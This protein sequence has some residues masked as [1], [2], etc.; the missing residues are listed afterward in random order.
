MRALVLPGNPKPWLPPQ[1]AEQLMHSV[2]LFHISFENGNL[3]AFILFTQYDTSVGGLQRTLRPEILCTLHSIAICA[4][5]HI[6]ND[7]LVD[8][9][10]FVRLSVRRISNLRK[11]LS[12]TVELWTVHIRSSCACTCT[13]VKCR[14]NRYYCASPRKLFSWASPWSTFMFHGLAHEQDFRGLA[15]Q[16]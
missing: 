14:L 16:K 2:A 15:H 8:V 9:S 1:S 5:R 6:P 10:V 4:C 13:L 12:W 11:I 3:F 7:D